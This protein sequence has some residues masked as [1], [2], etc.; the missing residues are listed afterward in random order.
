MNGLSKC[1][2]ARYGVV[3][4]C[5]LVGAISLA[6]VAMAGQQQASIFG[7]VKDESGGVLPGV[8][9]SAKSPALQVPQVDTVTD[10][11]GEYRLSPLPP[12]TYNVE[13]SL[14]GFGTIQRDGIQ[15]TIGFQ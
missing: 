1:R 15:L 4:V 7:Q 2:Q 5:V 13:Y 14:G 9:V 8:T 10:E 6:G 11:R 3:L 12:G